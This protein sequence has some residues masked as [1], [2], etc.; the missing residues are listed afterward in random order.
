MRLGQKYAIVS[1]LWV[2]NVFQR[3]NQSLSI[4]CNKQHFSFFY[5]LFAFK[6]CSL[7]FFDSS[8][9]SFK[10]QIFLQDFDFISDTLI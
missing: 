10:Q 7:C 4:T 1:Y 6:K 5:L 8:I 2:L 3:L 9:P